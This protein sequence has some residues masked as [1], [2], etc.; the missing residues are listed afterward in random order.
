MEMNSKHND[1]QIFI[2]IVAVFFSWP[3]SLP[4]NACNHVNR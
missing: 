2:R 4:T 3:W 1:S